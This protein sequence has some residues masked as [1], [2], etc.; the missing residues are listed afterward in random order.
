MT[1]REAMRRYNLT[2]KAIIEGDRILSEC[3]DAER[4]ARYP[5]YIALFKR[6]PDYV[7]AAG[8]MPDDPWE[9][10]SD[11]DYSQAAS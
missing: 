3:D 4:C 5:A 11:A 8:W 10:Y 7:Q 9:G 6:L 2:I 1:P